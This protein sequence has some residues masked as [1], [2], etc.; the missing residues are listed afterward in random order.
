MKLGI[1]CMKFKIGVIIF[2]VFLFFVIKIF[3]GILMIM[4]IILESKINVMVFIK[5][6]YK[7]WL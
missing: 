2:L 7:F 5:L 4:E 1:V 6:F 3:S